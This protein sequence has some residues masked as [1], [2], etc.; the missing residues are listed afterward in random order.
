MMRRSGWKKNYESEG[1]CI[2][3]KE[4]ESRIT[5]NRFTKGG[6]ETFRCKKFHVWTRE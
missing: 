3:Y 6:M 4:T 1:V 5:V 2:G